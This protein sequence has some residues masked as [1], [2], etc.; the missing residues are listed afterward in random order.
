MFLVGVSGNDPKNDFEIFL[1]N[2]AWIICVVV[3]VV[4]LFVIAL[5]IIKGRKNKGPVVN[6]SNWLD[7]LGGKDNIIEVSSTGSRLSV[8]LKNKELVNKEALNQ[9]GV[10]NIVSMSDKI[11]LVSE[12]DNSKIVEE[13]QKS[14]AN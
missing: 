3:V 12:L 5:I 9:L 2:Y 8:K 13:I 6:A 1:K 10:K 11:T 4:I 14:L 7:A